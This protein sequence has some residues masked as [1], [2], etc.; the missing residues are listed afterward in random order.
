[1]ISY[2][3]IMQ[4]MMLAAD[5]AAPATKSAGILE[6]VG[7]FLPIALMFGVMYFLI[8]RPASKQRREH[9]SLLNALKKDDEV[10]T[11]G[12]IFGRV[13]LVEES[14]VTLD[15]AEKTR[16]RVQRDRIAGLVKTDEAGKKAG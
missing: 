12:G 5:A 7:G 9:Q 2:A 15:I 8:I 16:V 6:T 14:V 10:V 11:S 3:T 4:T 1:M 13:V